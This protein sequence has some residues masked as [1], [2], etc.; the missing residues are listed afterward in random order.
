VEFVVELLF[1]FL[2]QLVAEVLLETGI[3]AWI[4]KAG[5]SREPSPVLAFLGYAFLGAALGWLSLALFP[6][7]FIRSI[8]WQKVNLVATPVLAGLAMSGLGWLRRR[9]GK[10]VL[11]IDRFSYGFVFAF[12]MALV[13]FLGA[14]R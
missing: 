9:Q 1:E 8:A 3:Q 5:T 2:L 7:L 6:M 12:A 11:R 13:R 4:D 10:V 14:S